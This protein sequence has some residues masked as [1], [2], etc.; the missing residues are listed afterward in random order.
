[1]ELAM[2]TEHLREFLELD[3]QNSTQ[4]QMETIHK[5][6]FD[7]IWIGRIP[8]ECILLLIHFQKAEA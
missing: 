2:G 7:D 3:L 4:N 1:M 5:G 8:I 6:R